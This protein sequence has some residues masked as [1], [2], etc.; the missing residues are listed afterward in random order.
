M[1][2]DVDKEANTENNINNGKEDA[3]GRILV[4]MSMAISKMFESDESDEEVEEK[5]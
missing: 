5:K 3:F 1:E 4:D 2:K